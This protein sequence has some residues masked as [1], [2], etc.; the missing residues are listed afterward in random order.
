MFQPEYRQLQ[1][2]AVLANIS[3]PPGISI[4]S[5]V[6]ADFPNVQR[7]AITEGW[8][9]FQDRPDAVL[10]AYENSWPVLVATYN[11]AVIGFVRALTDGQLTMYIAEILVGAEY[12]RL[13]I[14]RA[15]LDTC[16]H[17]YPNTRQDLLSDEDT[18]PFYETLNYRRCQGFRKS[19]SY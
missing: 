3:L 17:L 2:D 4:R 12:R 18:I 16:H 19:H 6:Q 8:S 1:L 5:W 7:L 11:D 10:T 13:G 9:S 15:L 14:G